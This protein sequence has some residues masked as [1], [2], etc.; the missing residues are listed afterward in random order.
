M[1]TLKQKIALYKALD[2]L[3]LLIILYILNPEAK[4]VSWSDIRNGSDVF[5]FAWLFIV[6]GLAYQLIFA[7]PLYL[8]IANNNTSVIGL[9]FGSIIILVFEFTFSYWIYGI[10]SAALKTAISLIV[11]GFLFYDSHY[12]EKKP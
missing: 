9:V 3:L 12:L 1:K 6:P 10:D 2:Y 8:M 7:F 5:M 11:F 4:F